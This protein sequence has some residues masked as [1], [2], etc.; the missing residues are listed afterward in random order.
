M[1]GR[2][3]FNKAHPTHFDFGAYQRKPFGESSFNRLV[4]QYKANAA[5][6]GREFALSDELVRSLTGS[7]CVYCLRP[8]SQVMRSSDS[9]GHYL[10]NG[11]DRVD[12]AIGYLTSNCVSCCKVCNKAK[13]NMSAPEW[14][15][16]RERIAAA[17]C[18]ASQLETRS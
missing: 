13:S 9:N 7:P 4:R 17:L 6:R 11:I 5:R 16:F 1:N 12:P 18:S 10:Y 15:D 3:Q 14:L 8:P 2:G